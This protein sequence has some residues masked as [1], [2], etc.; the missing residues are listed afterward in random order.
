M[1]YNI[2]IISIL[3]LLIAETRLLLMTL[4]KIGSLD[5]LLES[6]DEGWLSFQKSGFR[7]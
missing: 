2:R 3:F 5:I 6:N 4:S 1:D 7:S